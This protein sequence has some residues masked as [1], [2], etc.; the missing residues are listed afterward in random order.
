MLA[1][2]LEIAEARNR[3]VVWD[4]E[5]APARLGESTEGDAVAAAEHR[6]R[7]LPTRQQLSQPDRSGARIIRPEP[8]RSCDTRGMKRALGESLLISG[9]AQ[10]AARVGLCRA[11]DEA[12]ALMPALGEE[13]RHGFA[14]GV[15]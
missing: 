13:A 6:C 10:L 9:S 2:H 3:N 11:A 14:G 5:T 8:G 7:V 4:A 15:I 12:D 1:R